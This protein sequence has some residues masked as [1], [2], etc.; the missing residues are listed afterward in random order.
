MTADFPRAEIEGS[1]PERFRMVART[2][3]NRPAVSEGGRAV[4]YAE[5]ETLANAA[6][7]VFAERLAERSGPVA[8]F[9]RPGASLF[10]AMLGTLASGRSYVPLDPALPDARLLPILADLDAA[11]LVAESSS[12]ER[13]RTLAPEGLPVLALEAVTEGPPPAALPAPPPSPGD[14]AYVLFTSGST[15]RP[16]GVMQTHRNL[17]HNIWKLTS[18]LAI[19]PE[20]RWTLL[21]SPSFGASVSGIYGALLNGACVCPFSL[22]GDGLRRLPEFLE[23]EGITIYHSVPS[24][25]RSLSSTLDGRADLAR[26]RMIKLGGESVLASDLDLFRSR[27]AR[28]CVFHVGLGSTEVPVVRQW[29]ATHDTPWP[30]GTPLGYAV[31][32]TEVVLLGEDGTPRIG[33]DEGEIGVIAP[34]LPSGYWKDPERT[35]ATFVP[36]PGRPDLRMFRTGDLGRMLP[37]GCLLYAGRRDSRLK[38]RGQR[39]DTIDVEAALSRVPGV[40]EAAVDGRGPAGRVR[41]AAWVAG[42]PGPEAL[43]R[44]LAREL[45]AAMI[46]ATFVRVNALPR[47]ATGKVDRAALPEPGRARPELEVEFREPSGARETAVAEAFALV[48]GI[49]RVGADDDFFELGGDSLS[50]VEILTITSERLGVELTAADLIESPTPAGLAARG[51]VAPPGN[52]VRLRDGEGRPVFVVPGGAGDDEDLFAARR[53]ARVTGGGAPFFALRSGPAPHPPAEDLAARYVREIR[54]TG[55]GPYALVGDCMGGILAF[56]MARRLREEGESVRLLA[57]LDTPFP[58]AGRRLRAW[59]RRSAPRVDRLWTRFLYFGGRLRYHAGVVRQLPRGRFDYFRRAARTGARGFD[60]APDP[61]RSRS[62][63]R[64]ASYVGSLAAWKPRPFDGT[65]HL[66]ECAGWSERG[67]GAAWARLAADSRRRTVEGEHES[68]LIEHGD[69]VGAALAAWLSES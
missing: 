44:A 8:L 35:A 7:G 57:L 30:G 40:R 63:A 58:T 68:F 47:T 67:H 29:F 33:L 19:T 26:L 2:H 23:R 28:P 59:L 21:T 55:P 25:F 4:T 56:A 65:L 10:A 13:A 36:A 22:A 3:A 14:L 41:L 50:A 69:E 42:G 60:P 37:D 64:R 49:D 15:G 9:A 53:L 6:A 62:L 32:E 38:I 66:I 27:F 43:R 45:P 18:G 16:K 54:A 20:D 12:L 34:T 39:V 31:D 52:L 61:R 24:V 1:I 48:L 51:G 17:L 46:P 11:T 5:L